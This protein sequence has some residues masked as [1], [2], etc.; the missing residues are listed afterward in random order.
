MW[1]PALGRMVKKRMELKCKNTIQDVIDSTIIVRRLSGIEK[2]NT[3]QRRIIYIIFFL[4]SSYLLFL[5]IKPKLLCTSVMSAI[6]IVISCINIIFAKRINNK[7]LEKNILKNYKT[8]S[9]NYNHDFLEPTDLNIRIENG[10]VE[11]ESLGCITK[12]PVEDYIR[13]FKEDRFSIFEFKNGKY[14]FI[15]TKEITEDQI[16][17]F[18]KELIGK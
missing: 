5:A 15:D 14:I 4:T 10:F 2:K 12:Y 7:N 13:N 11:T 16:E 9:K 18:C 3:L 6:L 17:E 8:I 1:T